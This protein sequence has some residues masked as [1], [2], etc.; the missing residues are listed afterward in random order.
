MTLR[1]L[2]AA[3][4]ILFFTACNDD[5]TLEADFRDIPVA[6]AFLDPT[7]EENFV[8]VQRAFLEAGGNAEANAADAANLYYAEG[9]ATVRL[10]NLD[11]DESFELQRVDA[12][13]LGLVREPGTFATDPNVLYRLEDSND[14]LDPGQRVRLDIERDGEPTASATTTLLAPIDIIRPR[15]L[16]RIDDYRRPLIVSVNTSADA[17]LFDVRLIFNITE[18]DPPNQGRTERRL[19]FT[20]A[21]AVER[22]AGADGRFAIEVEPEDIYGFIA[23]QFAPTTTLIR[24]FQSMEVEVTAVG[25]EALDRLQLQSAN[26]GITSSQALPR[27]SNLSNGIGL[28]TSR[29]SGRKTELLLDDNSLDSLREGSFTGDLNFR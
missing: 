17:A 1:R 16:V 8:R 20:A 22:P 7:A 4:A 23:S 27:Y 24:R 12:S 15:E 28:I 9:A 14:R 11:T 25:T 5:F 10:T 13:V 2:T 29:T 26:A 18:F 6:Y 3:A 21:T 19:A